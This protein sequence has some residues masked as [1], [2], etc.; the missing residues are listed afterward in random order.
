MS[1][2]VRKHPR[3]K[4]YDYRSAGAYFITI[5]C[6]NYALI[7]GEIE[8]TPPENRLSDYGKAVAAEI[9]TFDK[10]YPYLTISNFTVMPNHLHLLMEM[11]DNTPIDDRVSVPQLV[12][13]I[14]SL[15]T[16]ACK[17]IGFTGERL[18]Q[19]SFHEHVIRSEQD[20][21]RIWEYIEHNPSKW[22]DD[23]YYTRRAQATRPTGR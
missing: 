23:R 10:R 16:R 18:Y 5:C 15:T 13:M 20:Y 11:H 3:L 4:E 2:P 12:G 14:K 17:K 21:Q 22:T 9:I 7:L 1:F 6:A 19:A 8:G